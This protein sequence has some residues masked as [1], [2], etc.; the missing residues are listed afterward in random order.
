MD[1]ALAGRR[2]PGRARSVTE[3]RV[4]RLSRGTRWFRR[5]AGDRGSTNIEMAILFPVFVLL[6]LLGVQVGLIFYGRTVALAA[7]QQGAVAEAAYGAPDG[8][9]HT[10]ASAYLTRM[11]D[12][13][14]DWEV[15]VAPAGEGAPEPTAV[16]VT[17]TGTT[18]GWLG[19]RFQ[20]SQTAYS[21]IEQF[22]TE[23]DS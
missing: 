3:T 22:T 4:R 16:R 15:T 19:M 12:V 8:I 18:L 20:I 23:D 7:A 2:S 6:I 10:Q 13:L 17:V 21:P 5:L 11:G 1:R 9:G 14:N